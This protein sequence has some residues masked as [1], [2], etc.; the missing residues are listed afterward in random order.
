MQEKTNCVR[1]RLR[2]EYRGGVKSRGKPLGFKLITRPEQGRWARRP[3]SILVL[4]KRYKDA[5]LTKGSVFSRQV[6]HNCCVIGAQQQE[7]RQ[8][9]QRQVLV[10]PRRMLGEGQA[11]NTQTASGLPGEEPLEVIATPD[12]VQEEKALDNA[13]EK[14]SAAVPPKEET[15][16]RADKEK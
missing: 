9:H 5:Q 16:K 13:Q 10:H 14:E 12:V 15:Q 3:W 6:G 4:S 1:T 8:I 7:R 2:E 11:W